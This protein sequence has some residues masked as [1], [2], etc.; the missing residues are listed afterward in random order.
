MVLVRTMY[1][2]FGKS[3]ISGF[4]SNYFLFGKSNIFGFGSNY[5]HHTNISL[6]PISVYYVCLIR[7]SRNFHFY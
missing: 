7:S 6:Y 3:N 2:L 5:F 4:G 1:F